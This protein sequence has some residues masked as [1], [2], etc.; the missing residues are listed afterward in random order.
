MKVKDYDKL[1]KLMD[2]TRSPVEAEAHAA[3]RQ[4]NRIIEGYGLTWERIFARTVTVVNEVE[5]DPERHDARDP[6]HD[7]IDDAFDLLAS[8]RGSFAEFVESLH[9]QW[10]SKGYLTANQKAA[11]FKAAAKVGE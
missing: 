7:R 4:A 3:L 6:D 5:E 9:S 11:L 2:M 10:K 8:V 1:R